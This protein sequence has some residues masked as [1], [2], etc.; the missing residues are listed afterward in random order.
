[1]IHCIMENFMCLKLRTFGKHLQV[2]RFLHSFFLI[3]VAQKI[4]AFLKSYL[5]TILKKLSGKRAKIFCKT[6]PFLQVL[7]YHKTIM[8][9]YLIYLNPFIHD[10]QLYG[11]NLDQLQATI[12]QIIFLEHLI[13]VQKYYGLMYQAWC[14]DLIKIMPDQFAHYS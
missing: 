14:L 13:M 10:T 9:F 6:G 12:I 5:K 1:M 8:C 11:H 3:K 7:I 4:N 2:K